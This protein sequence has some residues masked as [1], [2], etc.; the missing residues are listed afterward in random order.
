MP[1][2]GPAR[3]RMPALARA[4]VRARVRAADAVRIIAWIAASIVVEIA[5]PAQA[6]GQA[7]RFAPVTQPEIRTELSVTSQ[8]VASVG[9]GVNVPAGYY[10][11]V[12]TG[13]ALG[14]ALGADPGNVVRADVTVRFLADPF[15]ESRWGPYAGGGV[16][17]DWRHG[18]SGRA[19]LTLVVGT[20]LPGRTGWRPALELG[21]GDGARIAV[22][23]RHA[24]RSGR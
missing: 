16:A 17:V 4:L 20:D 10:V 23:F 18:R 13:V 15:A 21:V 6:S 19:A 11:R 1:T 12:G 5:A 2:G 7:Y 24:R 9:A 8:A 22:V 14:R 3:A